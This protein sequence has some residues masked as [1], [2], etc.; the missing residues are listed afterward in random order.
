MVIMK[1]PNAGY[2]TN[3]LTAKFVRCKGRFQYGQVT[4][5]KTN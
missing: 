4:F 2:Q 5:S 1:L 3:L